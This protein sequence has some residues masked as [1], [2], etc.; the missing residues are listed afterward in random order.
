MQYY[1]ISPVGVWKL[2]YVFILL[3]TRFKYNQF[4]ISEDDIKIVIA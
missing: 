2:Q 1:N 4:N 3:V